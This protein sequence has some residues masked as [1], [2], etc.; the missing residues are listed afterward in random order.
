MDRKIS[1]GI[2]R[3][4]RLAWCVTYLRRSLCPADNINTISAITMIITIP[5]L[6]YIVTKNSLVLITYPKTSIIFGVYKTDYGML[7]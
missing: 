2:M 5:T 7:F 4:G 3:L 6:T 1:S